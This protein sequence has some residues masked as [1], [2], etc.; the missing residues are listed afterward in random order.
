MNRNNSQ[1]PLCMLFAKHTNLD[2]TKTLVISHIG[3]FV[4]TIGQINL[5]L[6]LNLAHNI[7]FA[8]AGLLAG[9]EAGHGCD[10]C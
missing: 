1:T 5:F 10:D 4:L 2:V 8:G 7:G 9:G 6:G 3:A